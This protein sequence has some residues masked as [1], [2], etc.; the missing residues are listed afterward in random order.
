MPTIF[1]SW[2][3]DTS[4]RETREVFRTALAQAILRLAADLEEAERP[5]LDHDTRGV[6]GSPEIVNTIFQKIDDA[7]IFVADVTPIGLSANGKHLPNPN[8]LIELGYAK[9][10]LSADRIILLWN[11]ALHGSRPEDLP[12]D[13]RHRRAPMSVDIPVGA[14][15]SILRE[16]RELLTQGLEEAL[17]ASL[18]VVPSPPAPVT[19]WKEGSPAN[20]GV[21]VDNDAGLPVNTGDDAPDITIEGSRFGYARVVPSNWN[22]RSDA[23]D[24]LR[25]AQVGPPLLGRYGSMN[26]GPTRGGFLV[27]R[28]SPTTL[29]NGLTSTATRWYRDT[30]EFWG[31]DGNFVR[32]HDDEVLYAEPYSIGQWT[33][34]IRRAV[35][36]CRIVGGSGIMNV[37]LGIDNLAGAKWARNHHFGTAPRALEESIEHRFDIGAN[38]ITENIYSNVMQVANL[39]RSA[40]GIQQMSESDFAHIIAQGEF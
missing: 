19:P 13:L 18:R 31:V 15:R 29:E 2:Q 26:W 20:R 37:M 35:D 34:W 32:D 40:F 5:E 28:Q 3:S 1:W 10:S 14:E 23:V 25:N 17:R 24:V 8:V 21:W 4:A 30:G 9:K 7:A 38:D 39:V 27:F 12:F 36:S 6:P 33:Q 16:Q 11:T 22:A